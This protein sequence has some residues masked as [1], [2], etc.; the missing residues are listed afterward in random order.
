[1]KLNRGVEFMAGVGANM[2]H[3]TH[4]GCLPAS[5]AP[6]ALNLMLFSLRELRSAGC[7]ASNDSR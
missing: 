2:L 5:S 1:M 6:V 3:I 7:V 4:P